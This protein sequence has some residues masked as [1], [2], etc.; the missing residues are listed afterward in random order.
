MGVLLLRLRRSPASSRQLPASTQYLSWT[1]IIINYVVVVLI[2]VVVVI[3]I[4]IVVV[5]VINSSESNDYQL[6]FG[7][8]SLVVIGYWVLL[9]V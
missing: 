2:V 6:D 4:V 3:V 8:Y 9:F 7:F 1:I 5:V